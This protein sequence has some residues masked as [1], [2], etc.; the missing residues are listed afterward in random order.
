VTEEVEIAP[1]VFVERPK[2]REVSEA[3]AKARV[4]TQFQKG[5]CPNPGG[6]PVTKPFR[7]ALLKV[8][9]APE[10][11]EPKTEL[12]KVV[13]NLLTIAKSGGK[14]AVH[15]IKEIGDR[16]DGKSVPSAEEL[17]AKKQ[18]GSRILII[19]SSKP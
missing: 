16:I 8:I 18:S 10:G 5:I 11:F 4:A 17:D 15:A 13:I 19:N 9:T 2:K 6:R 12:E 3:L 7:D 14:G 1:A